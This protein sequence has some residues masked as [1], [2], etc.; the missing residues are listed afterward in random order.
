MGI[1]G[2]SSSFTMGQG[3][4]ADLIESD[5]GALQMRVSGFDGPP[6]RIEVMNLMGHRGA[7]SR[8]GRFQQGSSD[9]RADMRSFLSDMMPG[10]LVSSHLNGMRATTPNYV[11][12]RGAR[13]SGSNTNL[14]GIG[15]S[16]P[17]PVTHPLLKV[18]D[19]GQAR[20]LQNAGTGRAGSS[21]SSSGIFGAISSAIR[22]RG[23]HGHDDVRQARLSVSTR[24]RAL[25]PIVSDRRWGTDIGEVEVVGSRMPSLLVTVESALFDQIE[26][27]KEKEKEKAR[28]EKIGLS[29]KASSSRRRYLNGEED[30]ESSGSE[31]EFSG[32]DSLLEPF[33]GDRHN[34]GG[35]GDDEEDDGDEEEEAEAEL[36]DDADASDH[37]FSVREEEEC[38]EEGELEETKEG[39]DDDDEE[40]E[41]KEDKP[42]ES[43]DHNPS[44]GENMPD[45]SVSITSI[46]VPLSSTSITTS[47]LVPISTSREIEDNDD[48]HSNSAMS[49]DEPTNSTIRSLMSDDEALPVMMGIDMASS[50]SESVIPSDIIAPSATVPIPVP[51]PIVS[52]IFPGVSDEVWVALPFEMQTELLVS[53]GT[54]TG[55][56]IGTVVEGAIISEGMT[57]SEDEEAIA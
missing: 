1:R 22:E 50:S 51:V 11:H 40:E 38:K 53:I 4:G 45:N 54:G 19:P 17:Y 8:G 5:D 35:G 14:I 2:A 13:P 9:E 7:Q 42:L 57:D 30:G 46:T 28:K 29:T 16:S 39:D 21:T 6:V 52:G 23:L 31:D 10:S 55:T 15:S 47:T 56:G 27:P 43:D 3:F 48:S 25:G 36:Y 34:Y 20:L 33:Q 24:R 49:T 18:S 26:V 44:I 32:D 37:G 12:P 41:E